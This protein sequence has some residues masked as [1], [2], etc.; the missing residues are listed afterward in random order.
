MTDVHCHCGGGG[1]VRELVCGER[2]LGVH[3][4][5]ADSLA[6]PE[7]ALAGLRQA[8]AADARLGIGEI[9]LDRLRSRTVSDRM[10]GL[11]E[12]QL[13]LAFEFD[14]PLVLHGA[15]CWGQV[16]AAVVRAAAAV[17]SHTRGIL[18]HGFSRSDGL[19]PDIAAL[20]GFVSVGP[21]VLNAHAVNYR[22]MVAGLAPEL[23]VLETDRTEEGAGTCPSI[24]EIAAEVARLR[25]VS[26]DELEALTDA[27]AERFCSFSTPDDGR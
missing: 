5:A 17:P 3:P 23:L 15:K 24:P 10:R 4:W 18:F 6:E 8:L 14:R 20:G 2:F 21:A 11:F 13:E 9:G 26:V 1:G 27:N 19:L 25:G 12:S 22:R 7:R 16:V